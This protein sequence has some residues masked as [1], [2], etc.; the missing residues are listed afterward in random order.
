MQKLEFQERS[1][2]VAIFQ[3]IFPFSLKNGLEQKMIPVLKKEQYKPFR[4]DHLEDQD[5]YYGNFHISHRDIEAYF[6]SFTNR[7]LFPHSEEQKG[8]QRFSKALSLKGNLKTDIASIPFQIHSLDVILCPYE[9]GLITIRT[10][11]I[12]ERNLP[13]SHALEFAARFRMLEPRTESDRIAQIECNGKVYEQVEKF[14]FDYLFNGLTD[15][16]EKK[17]KKESYFQSFPYFEDERMYV[18]SL[19]A[20]PENQTFDLV[21]VYRA[22]GLCGINRE[23][24]PFVSAHNRSYIEDYVKQH[25]YHRWAPN[26]Y[27]ILEE[28]IFTCISNEGP[29]IIT[30]LASRI[31]GE[32]YY[33]LLLNLFHKIVL[34]K[35]AQT[36]AVLNIEEDTKEMEKLIY[37]INS[38]TANF[39]SLELVAQS[40]NQEIFFHLRK[41]FNIEILYKNAKQTLYSLFKYQENLN[42]KQDSLLLLILT[43][44]SV[45]GQMF[46]M[47]LVSGDFIG[48][49]K[50]RH[51]LH[52]NP[53]EYFALFLAV[54]GVIISLILG[55][56]G[57]KQWL[58]DRK[59]RKRWVRETILSSVNDQE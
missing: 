43:L 20:L 32:F 13:L 5:A 26:T 12:K 25:G 52:Y 57:L 53:V 19:L 21:D 16:F 33:G 29:H 7:I 45:I 6:L 51:M 59:N 3:F 15:F 8:L 55:F 48:K 47:S 41:T 14:V 17:T 34:L 49:I 50:W 23:G 9:L 58:T 27:F 38:F 37:S 11:V 56:Q 22:S 39:F 4:L 1:L 36:Y 28:N 30:E 18:Q 44:Y 2:D 42:S 54:S 46:G 24:K 40:Q 31:Y 35:I 10:E